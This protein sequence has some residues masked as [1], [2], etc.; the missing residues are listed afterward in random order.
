MSGSEFSV[1][2]IGGGLGG[3][4]L[5]H[6]LR[7]AGVPVT[8][9]ERD[10]TRDERLQGYRLHIDPDGAA[11]LRACLPEAN[12]EVL[13]AASGVSAPVFRMADE[14]LRTVAAFGP[15]P[16]APAEEHYSVSRITLRQ[17]LLW[18]L[19][20]TVV[21]DREFT[22]YE[23][24]AD[25][26]VVCR[27]A[28][29]SQAR[30]DLVVG[31]DGGGSRVRRRLLPGAERR[32]TG[33]FAVA[34]KLP[35]TE[36]TRAWLPPAFLQGATSVLPREHGGLFFT[37]HE[38][39]ES[40][41]GLPAGI[42]GQ[43]AA[44]ALN[45]GTLF[46]NMGSYVLWAYA[47]RPERALPAEHGL[48][49]ETDGAALRALVADRVRGW[50]PLLRR[51]IDGSPDDGVSRLAIR[52]A[53]DP[54]HWEP[55]TVTLLGDAIHSMTPM[56]GIGANVALR[57]AALLA[58]HLGGAR[59][60]RTGLIDAVGAYEAEMRRYGFAAVRRS[61]AQAHMFVGDS[62]GR[63]A[64]AKAVMRS[65]SAVPPLR[66][67]LFGTPLALTGSTAHTL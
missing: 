42:G 62:L 34:G 12:R 26:G 40:A 36:E 29:G 7:G 55:G 49:S 30:A 38:L 54:G 53:T 16:G 52:T 13:M 61:L 20:D 15:R 28:D 1:A 59:A 58:R 39:G 6:G 25:G 57:D 4:C 45:P 63:R 67:R 24:A 47:A 9:Y 37:S 2:V 10:R 33:I 46:D 27:F 18:G 8:V 60:G 41:A 32:D 65:V 48:P 66:R 21:F 22:G 3:L 5:A 56:A 35:L 43:D 44:H 19:E 51:M 14:R 11:A 17:A 64:A 31:A 23:H 50:H